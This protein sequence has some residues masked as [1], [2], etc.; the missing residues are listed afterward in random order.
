M[1]NSTIKVGAYLGPVITNLIKER[2]EDPDLAT[3]P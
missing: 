2:G 3:S 1:V